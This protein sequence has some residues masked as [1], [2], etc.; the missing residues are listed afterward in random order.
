MSIELA[1][2]AV[3]P[4]RV[5]II[6]MADDD[7]IVDFDWEL[8]TMRGTFSQLLFADDLA[9]FALSETTSLG[10]SLSCLSP[11]SKQDP[12][13]MLR[14]GNP[15]EDEST[16]VK[17]AFTEPARSITTDP[18]RSTSSLTSRDTNTG[19]LP[20]SK[21]REGFLH[22]LVQSSSGI[23]LTA[24]TVNGRSSKRSKTENAPSNRK[25]RGRRE[26]LG[27]R[28]AALQQLVS[29]HGK[30]DTA[31]VL[32]EAMGYIRFLHEQVQVL[33]SPY[34]QQFPSSPEPPEGGGNT[35]EESTSS[36]RKRSLRSR[37][38]CLIPL[39]CTAHVAA[40]NGADFWS[41]A[42]CNANLSSS[43]SPLLQ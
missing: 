9:G 23:V 10:S 28:I 21:R 34:L 15:K 17:A 3:S 18:K 24:P 29:P 32:H 22:G 14:F 39:A 7:R 1:S 38:L 19:C 4:N 36:L 25:T 6:D 27:E 35:G 16:E 30:T 20:T 2:L 43:S 11:Y 37:G 12:P 13:K 42:M 26:R 5:P 40:C 41:P 31:S 33:C 8:Q